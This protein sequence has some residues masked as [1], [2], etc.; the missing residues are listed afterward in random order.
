MRAA[1]SVGFTPRI[2]QSHLNLDR[3]ILICQE[4]IDISTL[5]R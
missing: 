2:Y 3:I 5:G 4:M 1:K